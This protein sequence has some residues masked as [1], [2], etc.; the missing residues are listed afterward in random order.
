MTDTIINTRNSPRRSIV[1][2]DMTAKHCVR[3]Y[4]SSPEDV[5]LQ[6]RR[7]NDYVAVSLTFA[8][9]LELA[10]ALKQAVNK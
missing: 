10:E 4:R 6:L 5:L 2:T 9:A 8:E 1:G 7:S 3:A